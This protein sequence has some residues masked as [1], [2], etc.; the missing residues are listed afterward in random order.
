MAERE[1][2]KKEKKGGSVQGQERW[3]GKTG[4]TDTAPGRRLAFF[5][6][7]F[8]SFLLSFRSGTSPSSW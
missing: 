6:I 1:S 3:A 7:P 5:G 2:V 8:V 4:K